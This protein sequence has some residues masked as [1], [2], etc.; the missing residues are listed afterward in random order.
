M[1]GLVAISWGLQGLYPIFQCCWHGDFALD[2]W[3]HGE[4]DFSDGVKAEHWCSWGVLC[5]L[6]LWDIFFS[7]AGV[8]SKQNSWKKPTCRSWMSSS[9]GWG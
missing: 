2:S 8:S 4:Q 7:L 5:H 3:C 6:L 1:K 9:D